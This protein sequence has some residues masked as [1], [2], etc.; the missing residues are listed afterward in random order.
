MQPGEMYRQLS[1]EATNSFTRFDEEMT[2]GWDMAQ[3][4]EVTK[5]NTKKNSIVLRNPRAKVVVKTKRRVKKLKGTKLTELQ[6]D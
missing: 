2:L 3:L 5:E 4:K 1:I 6:N